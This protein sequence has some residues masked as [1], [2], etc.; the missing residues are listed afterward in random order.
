M[1]QKREKAEVS[2]NVR[3]SHETHDIIKK[4]AD[5]NNVSLSE[6]VR[7]MIQRCLTQSKLFNV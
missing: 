1:I 3:V 2:I 4:L 7:Q 6:V 5:E